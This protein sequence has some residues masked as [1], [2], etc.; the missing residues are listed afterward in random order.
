MEMWGNDYPTPPSDSQ[1]GAG[2][3]SGIWSQRDLPPPSST[4]FDDGWPSPCPH[5]VW[6]AP[7]C[8]HSVLVITSNM[9][10]YNI[11][12]ACW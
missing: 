10:F 2:G 6:R 4:P 1:G 5:S 3:R 9:L 12:H 7:L 8:L 11:I